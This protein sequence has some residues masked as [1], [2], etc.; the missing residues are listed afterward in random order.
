MY[1][2]YNPAN[3]NANQKMFYLSR[4]NKQIIPFDIYDI[5]RNHL[6]QSE[7][8]FYAS[9]IQT[10]W[11]N[12]LNRRYHNTLHK[13]CKSCFRFRHTQELTYPEGF[14]YDMC[15][16]LCPFCRKRNKIVSYDYDWHT[17]CNECGEDMEDYLEYISDDD[18]SQSDGSIS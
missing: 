5:I 11:R 10:A 6:Y 1:D 9:R 3:Y 18:N 14:C 17:L 13:R 7:V 16:V 2:L 8:E 4:L 15:R 12:W